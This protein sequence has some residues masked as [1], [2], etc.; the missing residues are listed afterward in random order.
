M[1]LPG[2]IVHSGWVHPEVIMFSKGLWGVELLS[3]YV[4]GTSLFCFRTA[5]MW[6]NGEIPF[7]KYFVRGKI[8]KLLRIWY[9]FI[10]LSNCINAAELRNPIPQV[11]CAPENVRHPL[12]Q[13]DGCSSALSAFLRSLLG[14]FM[15]ST[16]TGHSQPKTLSQ[17][18]NRRWVPPYNPFFSSFWNFHY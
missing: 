3:F 4:F 14:S 5:L 11:L 17:S 12:S 1:F 2:F 8:F 6:P 9:T 7:H 15:C 18:G 13:P 16:L 10:L